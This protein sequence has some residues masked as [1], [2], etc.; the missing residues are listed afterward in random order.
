MAKII[1]L[2]GTHIVRETLRVTNRADN[3]ISITV[4]LE[5]YYG[6]SYTP[7]IQGIMGSAS[8]EITEANQPELWNLMKDATQQEMVALIFNYLMGQD[9]LYPAF[10]AHTDYM[11]DPT[12]EMVDPVDAE[13]NVI[14]GGNQ[15]K[16]LVPSGYEDMIAKAVAD[17]FQGANLFIFQMLYNRGIN[18]I[19]LQDVPNV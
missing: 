14:P 7:I 17:R 15:V 5:P 9:Q 1:L 18:T 3:R 6:V 12:Y 11:Q 13:G 2:N 16:T 8:F 4:V 10:M 19:T